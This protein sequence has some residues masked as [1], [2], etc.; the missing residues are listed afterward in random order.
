MKRKNKNILSIIVLIILCIS[1]VVTGYLYINNSNSTPKT[2]NIIG[3][4]DGNNEN[5][6]PEKPSGNN[7]TNSNIDFNGYKLYVSGKVIN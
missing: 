1:T 6:P 4:Q 2:Q 7:T 3:M 5:Q